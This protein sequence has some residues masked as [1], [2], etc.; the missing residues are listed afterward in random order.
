MI[1]RGEKTIEV[2]SWSTKYRGKLLI[3]AG[4]KPHGDDPTGV[5]VA[6]VDLVECRPFAPGD[7][8]AAC[9]ADPGDFAWLLIN[10]RPI[11]PVP[12]KGALG[13]FV[14]EVPVVELVEPT[15]AVLSL[16]DLMS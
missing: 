2:R 3:C 16:F 14:V 11:E 4:A 10:A 13:I 12:V 15:P 5:A 8:S 1:A 9:A 6:V 7:E